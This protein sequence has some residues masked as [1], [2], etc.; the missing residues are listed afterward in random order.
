MQ[1]PEHDHK[2]EGL[3]KSSPPA[4]QSRLDTLQPTVG[5]S[6]YR[7][8]MCQE[9]TLLATRHRLYILRTI[10]VEP[11]RSIDFLWCHPAR[12]IAHLLADVV[13]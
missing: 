12:D 5:P 6:G 4:G 13:A 8:E 1:R 11:A 2:V 3:P 7:A 10:P 9:L